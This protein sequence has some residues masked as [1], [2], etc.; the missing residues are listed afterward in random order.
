MLQPQVF[1]WDAIVYHL[2][3]VEQLFVVAVRLPH[4]CAVRQI[5][6]QVQAS[7]VGLLAVE[8]L[9]HAHPIRTAMAAVHAISVVLIWVSVALEAMLA[10]VMLWWSSKKW[11][12]WHQ[13]KDISYQKFLK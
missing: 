8:L 11:L 2:S 3:A 6:M 13:Q 1:Q 4:L 5:L 10:Q 9:A 7:V 12:P